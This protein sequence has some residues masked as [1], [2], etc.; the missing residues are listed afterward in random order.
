MDSGDSESKGTTNGL[1]GWRDRFREWRRRSD[2]RRLMGNILSLGYLQ[3]AQYLLPLITVPYLVRVL[4]PETFGLLAFA[5]ALIEYFAIFTDYGFNLSATREIAS[6]RGKDSKISEIFSAVLYTKLMLCVGGL[7][8]LSVIVFSIPKLSHDWPVYYLSYGMVLGNALFPLWY[9]LGMEKM[10]YITIFHISARVLSTVAIFVFIRGIDDYIYVPVINAAGYVPVAAIALL[11]AMRSLSGS[12]WKIGL[13]RREEISYQ[14][15]QA[16]KFFVTSILTKASTS[17]GV[18]LSGI[19]FGNVYAGYFSI[20]EKL[21]LLLKA[22]FSPLTQSLYPFF[23]QSRN[24][25]QLLRRYMRLA[26]SFSLVFITI[27][28]TLYI[29]S[30]KIVMLA[31]GE[32]FLASAGILRFLSPLFVVTPMGILLGYHIFLPLK[33]DRQFMMTI[34]VPV[35]ILVVVTPL[36]LVS[37]RE[38]KVLLGMM[39]FSET[40]I[41]ALRVYYLVTFRAIWQNA[42]GREQ[43]PSSAGSRDGRTDLPS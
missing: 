4:E 25:P 21:V 16:S 23:A 17:S 38:L 33:K 29:F 12:P 32:K 30:D 14:F 6:N 5:Q 24:L 40:L 9:Y 26:P 42:E 2:N 28:L 36:L 19:F 31:F 18:V 37:F 43:P 22:M 13:P 41:L 7:L 15:R 39:L 3:G 35:L 11:T 34:I 8:V 27:G 10:K 1:S 20:V